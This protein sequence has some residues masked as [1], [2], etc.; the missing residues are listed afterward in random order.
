MIFFF[1]L[2]ELVDDNISTCVENT[3]NSHDFCTFKKKPDGLNF[4]STLAR[5]KD[6]FK[7][8]PFVNLF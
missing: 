8:K 2:H 4:L 5:V 6:E 7:K 3:Y 1:I